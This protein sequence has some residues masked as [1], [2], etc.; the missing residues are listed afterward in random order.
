VR[1]NLDVFELHVELSLSLF[2]SFFFVFQENPSVVLE[3]E[4]FHYGITAQEHGFWRGYSYV[5]NSK[6][7]STPD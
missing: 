2:D 1:Q 6:E 3:R 7:L 4:F 5:V